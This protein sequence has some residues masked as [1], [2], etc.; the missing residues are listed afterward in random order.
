MSLSV[1]S[2]VGV[3]ALG[4][5]V[6][7]GLSA[8]VVVAV[9]GLVAVALANAIRLLGELLEVVEDGPRPLADDGESGLPGRG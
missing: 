1:L 2:V 4:G 6:L 3:A 9:A 8:L 7:A 5:G